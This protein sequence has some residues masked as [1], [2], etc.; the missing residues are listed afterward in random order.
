MEK[1]KDKIFT[2]ELAEDKRLD[3]IAK[4]FGCKTRRNILRLL[5]KENLS[6]WNIAQQL[7]TPVS[8]ISE[9]IKIL[10]QSGIVSLQERH[11]E[12]GR[13]KIVV[14]QY[15]KIEIPVVN[16]ETDPT[17]KGKHTVHIPIGSYTSFHIKKYCGMI[18][19]EGYIGVTRDNA[20]V[21]YD[22]MRFKAQL[23]WFDEGYL[24]YVV[25]IPEVNELDIL[26]LSL[27]LEICSEAPGYNSDW[28]SDIFFELNGHEACVYTSP[29]DFGGR[30]GLLTPAWWGTYCTQYGAM[31]KVEITREGTFLDNKL[32]S[33][34]TL[35][36]LNL[37]GS[38]LLVFRI[39]VRADAK[40]K[41]GINLFGSKF[42]DYK[43]HIYLNITYNKPSV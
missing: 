15:E 31:K 40:N 12:K 43:Q 8:T 36:D 11:M 17:G 4:A 7:D 21:F 38:E 25:P 34:L 18:S 24:E 29:G 32:V 3:A 9:H 20:D 23:L 2:V 26:S 1:V 41:G 35:K 14:R 39:G 22:P 30:Q 10:V 16:S 27:S 28:K 37:K 6:I 42:W 5:A 19:E 33:D 13:E